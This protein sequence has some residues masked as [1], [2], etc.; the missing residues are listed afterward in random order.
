MSELAI[1]THA[2]DRAELIAEL[3]RTAMVWNHFA[4]AIIDGFYPGRNTVMGAVFKGT[5]RERIEQLF[6]IR[7]VET[8]R[9]TSLLHA[10]GAQAYH[11]DYASIYDELST[12]TD[13]TSTSHK[14]L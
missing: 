7:D 12:A 8:R 14:P 2:E 1:R 13:V 9:L 3:Q 4:G 10:L 6:K 5:D 11:P